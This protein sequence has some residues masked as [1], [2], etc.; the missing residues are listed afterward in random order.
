M[1]NIL[2]VMGLFVALALLPGCGKQIRD[3]NR[4]WSNAWDGKECAPQQ[5][6]DAPSVQAPASSEFAQ[7]Q[8][9]MD[10][11][12]VWS[13]VGMPSSVGQTAIY[14][15][16]QHPSN[17]DKVTVHPGPRRVEFAFYKGMG[18]V[19]YASTQDIRISPTKEVIKVTYN[20]NE[21]GF[22]PVQFYEE[23]FKHNSVLLG[24]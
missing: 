17:I 8:L 12:Q 6:Y 9:G 3:L 16:I 4:S 23:G 19:V 22:R 1:K 13:I 5:E 2:V 15:N 10:Y 11:Q 20:P 14:T 7:I 21:S 24:R 18:S